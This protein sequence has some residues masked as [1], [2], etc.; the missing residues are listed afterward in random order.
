[1]MTAKAIAKR[2][3]NARPRQ[4]ALDRSTISE[5]QV[6]AMP[7]KDYMGTMQLGFFKAKLL[8][9]EQILQARARMAE[10]SISAGAAGADPVDRA[11]A[12]EEHTLALTGRARDAAQLL[13]VRAALKRI[14]GGEY[15]YCRETGDEI[16]VARLLI[17][18]TAVL[19]TEAQERQENQRRRFRLMGQAA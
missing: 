12:E 13:E 9:V 15:G 18:P 16:G 11:S 4:A 17:C 14:E 2:S 8:M 10:T 1:M 19:T 6:L 3:R 7:A 5:S